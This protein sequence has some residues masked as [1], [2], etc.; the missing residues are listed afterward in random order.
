[1]CASGNLCCAGITHNPWW[2]HQRVRTVD[3]DTL[4]LTRN[5]YDIPEVSGSTISSCD[6]VATNG[7]VHGIDKVLVPEPDPWYMFR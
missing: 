7:V 2:L 3:G 5:R 6:N 4:F 1:M